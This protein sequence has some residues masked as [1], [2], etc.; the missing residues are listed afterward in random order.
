MQVIQ[1]ESQYLRQPASW[2]T[3]PYL[4]FVGVIAGN[5]TWEL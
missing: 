4:H 1:L 5:H 3:Y 2:T